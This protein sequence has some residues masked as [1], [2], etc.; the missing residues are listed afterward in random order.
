MTLFASLWAA[1]ALFH[2]LASGR[3]VDIFSNPTTLGFSLVILAICAMWLLV[4][5]AQNLPLMLVAVLGLITTWLEAPILGNHWLLV[6]FVDLGLLL[7]AASTMRDGRINRNK[8][9]EVFLPLARWCLVLFY[10]FAAF[11][12]LNSA[13][14]DTAVSCS[15]Y[16]F[17]ETARSLGVNAPLVV[18]GDL[19]SLLPYAVAMIELS[20]PILLFNRRTRIF[21]V[22]LGLVFHSLIALDRIHLFVDFSSVLVALFVLFLPN[23]FAASAL[24]F[25]KARGAWLPALWAAGAG[26]VLAAPWV[27]SNSFTLHAFLEGRLSLWYI[28]DAAILMG[29]VI[30]LVRHREHDLEHPFTVRGKGAVWLA[31]VPVLLVLNGLLPY[32][33]LRTAYAYNMYSNLRMVDGESNHFIIRSSLPLANRQADLVKVVYSDDPGLA[34]Y[35]A[36]NYLLPWDSFRAYLARHPEI[37]VVYERGDKGYV[38]DRV[39]NYPELS[40]SPPLL[41]RKLFAL[42]AVDGSDK[43]R[44]QDVFL[45]A[46]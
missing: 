39:S 3:T 30:W 11:A 32:F 4:R 45:P 14:F 37:T 6:A 12:K 15:T 29:V 28:F 8:T 17:D 33:E 35:A 13:F 38:I 34:A 23:Q 10:S 21:A 25:L 26:L 20:I 44:C 1:A 36:N 22:V 2:V 40:T 41:A 18:V 19:A 16:Y 46:L 27:G 7:S 42:R 5:P 24:G 31:V 43:P 9:A